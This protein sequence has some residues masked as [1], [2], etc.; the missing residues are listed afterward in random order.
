[1][2][3]LSRF[4]NP[5]PRPRAPAL[6]P[7]PRASAAD[8]RSMT[9]SSVGPGGQARVHHEKTGDRRQADFHTTT[10][11]RSRVGPYKGNGPPEAA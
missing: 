11:N 7:D 4:R 5:Q 10:A 3:V 2:G 8:I 1:M 6:N 9:G